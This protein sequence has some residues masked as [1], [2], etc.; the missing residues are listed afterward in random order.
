MSNT[1]I[2]GDH[3]YKNYNTNEEK[4]KIDSLEIQIKE[5]LLS[6]EETKKDVHINKQAIHKIRRGIHSIHN[7]ESNNI[8][9]NYTTSILEKFHVSRNKPIIKVRGDLKPL[10]ELD[11]NFIS[12]NFKINFFN[13]NH[14][15]DNNKQVSNMVYGYISKEEF[16]N[17]IRERQ[18]SL[19]KEK[20]IIELDE[21]LK[22]TFK[23]SHTNIIN[24]K[25]TKA[26]SKTHKIITGENSIIKLPPDCKII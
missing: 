24:N 10:N 3:L 5:N 4:I 18:P 9:L 6:N 17:I 11:E 2:N 25:N 26:N 20:H 7:L 13:N 1:F 19:K 16:K 14:N 21:E 12:N 23:K 15:E 22:R 8:H